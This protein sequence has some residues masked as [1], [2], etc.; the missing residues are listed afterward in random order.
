[1][2]NLLALTAIAMVLATSTGCGMCRN[3]FGGRAHTVALPVQTPAAYAQ[4][5]YAQQCAPACVPCCPPPCDPCGGQ[6]FGPGF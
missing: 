2:K 6:G 5:T 1:M 4:P 3:M